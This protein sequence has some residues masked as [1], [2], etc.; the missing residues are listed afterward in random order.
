MTMTIYNS[1]LQNVA[2]KAIGKEILPLYP[3][4]PLKGRGYE[5]FGVDRKTYEEAKY[6]APNHCIIMGG[7]YFLSREVYELVNSNEKLLKIATDA[8]DNCKRVRQDTETSCEES[9]SKNVLGKEKFYEVTFSDIG[10][11]ELYFT[12]DGNPIAFNI[13]GDGAIHLAIVHLKEGASEYLPKQVVSTG[14]RND[15]QVVTDMML[16]KGTYYISGGLDSPKVEINCTE[17]LR[18]FIVER[19]VYLMSL[20]N[21][22]TKETEKK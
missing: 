10:N 14:V 3:E 5:R 11:C 2:A 16:P 19:T 15:A 22:T 20:G 8:V 1:E 7:S 4:K 18:F 21:I 13:G 12:K 17:R 6:F 9:F